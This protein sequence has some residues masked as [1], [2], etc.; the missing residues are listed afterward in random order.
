MKNKI[1]AVIAMGLALGLSQAKAQDLTVE[2]NFAFES[3]YVF[4][5]VQLATES[6]Q[7]SIDIGYDA[8][9][10][11]LWTNQPTEDGSA[12]EIDYY[13]GYKFKS[14]D[15]L[16]STSEQPFFT[17]QIL[18]AITIRSNRSLDSRS[19]RSL[20]RPFTFTMTTTWKP[21]LTKPPQVTRS[22]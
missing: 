15:L 3:E 18:R 1:L 16:T 9:Y 20:R 12:D 6:F 2:T 5:G 4:R 22:R 17:T 10:L 11:G 13:A 7:P 21:S 14:N 19:T 8:F